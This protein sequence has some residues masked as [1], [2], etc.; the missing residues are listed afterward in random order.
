MK[1]T[2]LGHSTVLVEAAGQRVLVDPGN[3]SSAWHGLDSLDA[4]CVTHQHPDHLDLTNLPELLLANPHAELILERGAGK[5][6]NGSSPNRIVE[7]NPGQTAA[8][9]EMRIVAHGGVHAVIHRDLEP[10]GNIGL[11]F[12]APGEPTFFHPGDALDSVPSEVDVLAI[13]IYGPWAAMKETIDFVRAVGAPQGF[14]IHE[15]LLNERGWGL[16][17]GRL[18]AMT[19]TKT[20]DLRHGQPWDPESETTS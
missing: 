8:L 15:G 10:L 4:I 13:P 20:Q 6:L 5:L 2:H 18:N 14:P 16:I 19:D 11:L 3:F 1:L 12:T 9:G 17:F 7:L